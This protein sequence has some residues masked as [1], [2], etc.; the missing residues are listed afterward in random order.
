MSPIVL[1][2]LDGSNPLSFLA[3]LGVLNTLADRGGTPTLSWQTGVWHAV[4]DDDTLRDR[5]GL[6]AASGAGSRDLER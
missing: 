1:T 6:I 5:D 4:V 2:G 3:G